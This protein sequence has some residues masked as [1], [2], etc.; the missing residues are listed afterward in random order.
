MLETIKNM[1][2][3]ITENQSVEITGNTVLLKDLDINSYDIVEFISL[4]EEEFDIEISD[5]KIKTFVTVNDIIS[6]IEREKSM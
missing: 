1:I 4:V 5:K 3:K 2:Y 6:Y